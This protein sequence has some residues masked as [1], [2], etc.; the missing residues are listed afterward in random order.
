MDIVKGKQ[1]IML[2]VRIGQSS[3]RCKTFFLK[4]R[5]ND[6]ALLESRPDRCP[7]W[8]DVERL[9]RK[10]R[11]PRISP[12]SLFHQ[13]SLEH[14]CGTNRPSL[15]SIVVLDLAR[16]RPLVAKQSPIDTKLGVFVVSHILHISYSSA[17][18]RA[19]QE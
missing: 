17:C 8:N 4:D 19:E 16:P 3:M 9:A 2:S 6:S 12:K 18:S 11:D 5:A 13:K 7:R 10:P 15:A 14:L 1:G